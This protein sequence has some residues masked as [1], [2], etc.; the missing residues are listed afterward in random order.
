MLK[1]INIILYYRYLR[2]CYVQKEESSVQFSI[3]SRVLEHLGRDLITSNEV[4]VTELIKNSYDAKAKNVKIHF[5]SS[6]DSL[7]TNNLLSPCDGK[8]LELI[9]N[10]TREDSFMIIEDNGS[11]MG[12]EELREGFFTIGTDIKRKQKEELKVN[13]NLEERFP[14]GEKGIGRLATQRLSKIL[15]IETTSKTSDFTYLVTV[16]WR[17]FIKNSKKLEEIAI[18]EKKF[19]KSCEFY[20]RLWFIDLNIDFHSFI[21]DKRNAQQELFDSQEEDRPII[22]LREEFQSALSFLI[23]PF[24]RQ[25]NDFN[26]DIWYDNIQ[27]KAAFDNQVVKIA[28]NEYSFKLQMVENELELQAD[29]QIKPWYIERIH[30]QLVGKELFNDWKKTPKFYSSLINKYQ[31]RFEN[32]MSIKWPEAR[33]QEELE[34]LMDI[35]LT[36]NNI[37]FLKRISP[38]EGKVYS[39]KRD[40]TLSAMAVE[41]AKDTA[42][43]KKGFSVNRVKEFLDYHMGIKL[44]RGD[45]RIA[46]LGDKDSD[47][48]ELQKSRTRGQQFFRFEL[49]NIIG[50]VKI[51]DPFQTYI[52]EISS[53]L[54]LRQN[55]YSIILKG[56]LNILFHYIFYDFS[57]S[58]YYIVKD[59][60]E[61]EGLLPDRSLD[62]LK[63]KMHDTDKNL[64]ETK[65][66]FNT[67]KKSLSI[68]QRNINMETKEQVYS[69]PI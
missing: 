55:E 63:G 68:I 2:K 18:E 5:I 31:V 66:H 26:I 17:E 46:A 32:T 45:F 44:Y 40:R 11:G 37:D 4:A 9:R 29:M 38:I 53:R 61:E 65:N 52:K 23:S 69:A 28:E 35:D 60:I 50:Y 21:I 15:L 49:G 13:L 3:S 42:I 10:F 58:A 48:L 62:K 41:S 57:R 43:I 30:R 47:W 6:I 7:D 12:I 14:L 56:F 39:F 16:D 24:D 8:L 67:L 19:S 33:I 36:I 22:L 20:T 27:I 51:N 1:T 59:I 34:E 25:L 54:D 64:K